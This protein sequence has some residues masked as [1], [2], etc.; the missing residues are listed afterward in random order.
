MRR[1]LL[2]RPVCRLWPCGRV[3]TDP[4][5]ATVEM[6]SAAVEMRNAPHAILAARPAASHVTGAKCHYRARISRLDAPPRGT[7][8]ERPRV[9]AKRS[10]RPRSPSWESLRPG[11][12][13]ANL[14]NRPNKPSGNGTALKASSSQ[15]S[16]KSGAPFPSD[17]PSL[18]QRLR[19]N[20]ITPLGQPLVDWA[21][22]DTTCGP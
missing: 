20:V 19:S 17:A 7:V 21:R 22:A 1:N 10:L 18:P 14:A 2:G 5:A 6:R 12:K 16:V 9:G 8:P 15:W 4:V 3:M 13:S 11:G